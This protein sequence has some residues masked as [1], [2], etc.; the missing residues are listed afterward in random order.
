MYRNQDPHGVYGT[1]PMQAALRL[2]LP[3]AEDHC[4]LPY[5]DNS[6]IQHSGKRRR[7]AVI[8]KRVQLNDFR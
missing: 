3:H 6:S 2:Y 5:R 8:K 4:G 1:L 7:T